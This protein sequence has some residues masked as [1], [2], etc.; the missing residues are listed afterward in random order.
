MYSPIFTHLL[1]I[2]LFKIISSPSIKKNISSLENEIKDLNQKITDFRSAIKGT[3]RDCQHHCEKLGIK[4]EELEKEVLGLTSEIPILLETIMLKM[5]DKRT[6]Q[7]L[8]YYYDFTKYINGKQ[9]QEVKIF[10]RNKKKI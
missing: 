5:K 1:F 4:G 10:I 8:K 6:G 3:E 2:S 7:I 9:D